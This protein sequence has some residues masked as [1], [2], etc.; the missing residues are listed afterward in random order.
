MLLIVALL[1]L[2]A[3]LELVWNK[4]ICLFEQWKKWEE[5][6]NYKKVQL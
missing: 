4:T 1:A 5:F 6:W 3:L 2:V